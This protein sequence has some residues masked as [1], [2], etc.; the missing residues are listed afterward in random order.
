M[1]RNVDAQRDTTISALLYRQYDAPGPD[2]CPPPE[3]A[4]SDCLT[5]DEQARSQLIFS[6]ATGLPRIVGARDYA[7]GFQ[8]Q[9]QD[10]TRARPGESHRTASIREPLMWVTMPLTPGQAL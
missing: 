3:A 4:I 8:R 1:L 6:R 10:Y 5:I 2:Q 7:I 9:A